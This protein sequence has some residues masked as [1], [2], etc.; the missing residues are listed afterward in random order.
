MDTIFTVLIIYLIT[1]LGF[2]RKLRA[3]RYRGEKRYHFDGKRFLNIGHEHEPKRN[4]WRLLLEWMLNRKRSDWVWRENARSATPV[5]RVEGGE[6]VVTFINHASVLIQTQ[7]LNILTDPVYAY[8]VSPFSWLGPRRFRAPGVAFEKLPPIDVVLIS[9][10]HYDHMDVATLRRLH[11]R[12]HPKIYVG[13]GNAEY[14]ARYGIDAHEM[15]WWDDATLGDA[16]RLVAV[17]AQHFSSRAISDRDRTLWCGYVIETPRGPIYFAGDTGHGPF[18]NE[19]KERYQ[20]FLLGLIPI[21]A[22][23]PYF[24]MKRVHLSP[25][26]AYHIAHELQVETMIPVH[27]GTFRLAD[28]RQDEPV[29]DLLKAMHG[30][31]SPRVI[32]LE[33]GDDTSI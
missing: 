33:N 13:L 19:I 28:D 5:A 12:F 22:F 2:D 3:K 7:G 14:L 26:E 29:N 27:Y 24:I 23:L 32:I 8:R 30:K 1:Y 15:D 11:Q 20:K 25:T 6:V 4:E 31:E 10:N 9:H 18:L 21:G 17:P 16:L